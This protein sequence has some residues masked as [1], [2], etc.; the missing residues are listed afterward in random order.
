MGCFFSKNTEICEIIDI[1]ENN[2]LMDNIKFYDNVKNKKVIDM[3][4][5][6]NKGIDK[7]M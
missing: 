6:Q 7:I 3:Y 5:I 2:K 1:E 4:D